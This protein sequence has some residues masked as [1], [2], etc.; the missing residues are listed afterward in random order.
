MGWMVCG[1]SQEGPEGYLIWATLL[2]PE[3]TETQKG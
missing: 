1:G 2:T 3:E